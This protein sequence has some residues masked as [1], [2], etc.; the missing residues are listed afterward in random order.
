MKI[1]FPLTEHLVMI[2]DKNIGVYEHGQ[3]DGVRKYLRLHELTKG[4]K[5]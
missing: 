5:R 4:K 2:L 3:Q 1:V